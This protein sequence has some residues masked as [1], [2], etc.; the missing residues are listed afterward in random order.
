M[1]LSAHVFRYS[2]YSH[3]AHS[4]RMGVN[5]ITLTYLDKN[6]GLETKDFTNGLWAFSFIQNLRHYGDLIE[7]L[8]IEGNREN[9]REYFIEC[10]KF[11]CADSDF[12]D[13]TRDEMIRAFNESWDKGNEE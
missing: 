7:I 13:S 8:S 9:R 10:I 11:V 6:T 1:G 4:V 3:K 12:K 5:V 2:D